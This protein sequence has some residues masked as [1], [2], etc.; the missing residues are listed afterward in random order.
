[1]TRCPW[2]GTDPLMLSYHDTEWGTPQKDSKKLFANLVIDGFQ[3][4]LS[5]RIILYKRESMREAFLDFDPEKLA[6]FTEVDIERLL[7][8]LGIIR[9]R[10]KVKAGITN[11]RCYIELEKEGGSFSGF[12][13]SFVDGQP[14]QHNYT[15][16]DHVGATSPESDAMSLAL[17]ARGFKFVGSTICYAFMQGAG[18]VNDHLVSCFR[19]SDL[20]KG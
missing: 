11:A 7:Q 1:M 8:N 9:N 16:D 17:K 10:A 18:L 19:H 5:W 14:I 3:A 20:Q 2:P 15:Q 12:L 6:N 13:W 4:G